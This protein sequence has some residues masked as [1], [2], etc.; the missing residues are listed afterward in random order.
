MLNIQLGDVDLKT[1]A[2]GETYCRYGE[3][4]V[5]PTSSSSSRRREGSR[6]IT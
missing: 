6:T 3:S 1:F 4:C 2:N 5:A